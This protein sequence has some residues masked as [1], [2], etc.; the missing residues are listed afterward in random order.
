MESSSTDFI[1]VVW[2]KAKYANATII[3]NEDLARLN[4]LNKLYL[5]EQERTKALHAEGY[6]PI[7]LY[8]KLD[9]DEALD[10]LVKRLSIFI[11][12][13]N[14]VKIIFKD[15]SR[16]IYSA[17]YHYSNNIGNVGVIDSWINIKKITLRK[18]LSLFER[19]W[20]TLNMG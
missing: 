15:N 5:A 8:S 12:N 1:N 10:L 17:D 6:S 3:I 4:L 7:V 19:I 16:L 11:E 14:V 2:T 18:P 13:G 20:L 9:I